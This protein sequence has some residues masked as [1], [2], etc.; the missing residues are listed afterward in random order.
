VSL[1]PTL[2]VQY[3][4]IEKGPRIIWACGNKKINFKENKRKM[5]HMSRLWMGS[6]LEKGHLLW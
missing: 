6:S 3:K 4:K 5:V 2:A 1:C